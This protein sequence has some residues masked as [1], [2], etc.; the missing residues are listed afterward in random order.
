MVVR[1]ERETKE[2]RELLKKEKKG[3]NFTK[4]VPVHKETGNK[5][6]SRCG[7]PK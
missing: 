5:R 4:R 2:N 1:T 6:R 7:V 3:C